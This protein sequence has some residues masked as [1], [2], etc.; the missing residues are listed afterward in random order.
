LRDL[1]GRF[2]TVRKIAEDTPNLD[3]V[4]IF[5]EPATTE[6]EPTVT[7]VTV[8]GKEIT[9]ENWPISGCAVSRSFALVS[10]FNPAAKLIML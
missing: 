5:L 6:L 3:L 1:P 8:Q 2:A 4:A 10:S 9:K 7:L